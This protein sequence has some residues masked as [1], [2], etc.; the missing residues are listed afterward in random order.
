MANNDQISDLDDKVNTRRASNRLLTKEVENLTDTNDR[1]LK[2]VLACQGVVSQFLKSEI[3]AALLEGKL[4][5]E[6]HNMEVL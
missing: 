2:A 3:R 6:P 4:E 1:M 5:V